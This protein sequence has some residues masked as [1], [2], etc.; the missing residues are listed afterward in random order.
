M[1]KKTGRPEKELDWYLL[2]SILQFGAKLIDCSEICKMSE[3]SIQRKIKEAHGCTFSEYREKKLSNTRVKLLKKQIEVALSGNVPM[4]IWTGKQ[5]LGQ[6]DKQEVTADIK[7][8][9]TLNYEKIKDV[10]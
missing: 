1:V 7:E 8:K 3:D 2:D 6:F 4:L 9:I 10:D 5:L